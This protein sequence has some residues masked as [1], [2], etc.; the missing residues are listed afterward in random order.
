[1]NN[2]EYLT[3]D[4]GMIISSREIGQYEYP[5]KKLGSTSFP[6]E[7]I[8]ERKSRDITK[9]YKYPFDRE[10]WM[11]ICAQNTI[12]CMEIFRVMN[13]KPFKPESTTLRFKIN[14]LPLDPEHM[15]EDLIKFINNLTKYYRKEGYRVFV[16]LNWYKKHL[17][18]TVAEPDIKY[19]IPGDAEQVYGW[20]GDDI[21]IGTIDSMKVSFPRL[22]FIGYTDIEEE[23]KL[24]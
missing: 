5:I 8:R 20:I 10:N 14:N 9:M 24:Q 23:I 16:W 2:N 19:I 13:S 22:A 11:D 7:L 12:G 1:M 3:P 15:G 18:L 6:S 4:I 21:V 17:Y